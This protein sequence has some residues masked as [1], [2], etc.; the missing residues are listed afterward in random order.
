MDG[1]YWKTLLK[2][3]IC[4]YHYFRKHPFHIYVLG[5]P[6]GEFSTVPIN[7]LNW[8][9]Q[10]NFQTNPPTAQYSQKKRYKNLGYD[11]TQKAVQIKE[12]PFRKTCFLPKNPQLGSGW[13]SCCF[14]FGLTEP[15]RKKSPAVPCCQGTVFARG[16]L[17]VEKFNYI[18]VL[19]AVLSARR[20][21]KNS[22]LL[23]IIL[24]A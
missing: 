23:C 5:P 7:S 10:K 13:H 24:V 18:R 15:S 3:M 2:W 14:S 9:P 22:L 17:P 4:G 8:R 19:V 20:A 12:F 21:T 11:D 6:S 16:R 1:L